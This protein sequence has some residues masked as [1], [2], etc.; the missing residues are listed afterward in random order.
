MR[1]ISMVLYIIEKPPMQTV[2]FRF[3]YTKPH[4][5]G[6]MI[7]VWVTLFYSVFRYLF[8]CFSKAILQA[9]EQKP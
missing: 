9:V 4:E 6:T 5:V 1:L 8:G 3:C 7:T 2:F